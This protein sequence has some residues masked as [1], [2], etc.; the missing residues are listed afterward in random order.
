M[1]K[2]EEDLRRLFPQLTELHNKIHELFAENKFLNDQLK[3]DN[4]FND[5]NKFYSNL[6]EKDSLLNNLLEKNKNLESE[7]NKLK[8]KFNAEPNLHFT[9]SEDIKFPTSVDFH[10]NYFVLTKSFL[11]KSPRLSRVITILI[12]LLIFYFL[13]V[14]FLGK[15]F[16]KQS[17]Q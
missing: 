5:I 15:K 10:D 11:P 12:F 3:N 2:K 8:T 1:N 17:L 14:Y 16:K 7:L 4:K 13:K 9:K 6:F